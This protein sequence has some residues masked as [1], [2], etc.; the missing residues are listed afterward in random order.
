MKPDLAP[1]T[2]ALTK[3][4]PAPAYLSAQAK[5]EWRRIMPQLIARRIITP[6]RPL[7]GVSL[8]AMRAF[9]EGFP[10]YRESSV[11]LSAT[12]NKFLRE[13]SLME[14]DDYTLYSLRHSFEDRMLAAGID[15]R[16]RRDLCRAQADTGT[17]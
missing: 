5:A 3:A 2:D 10:R 14:S 17:L 16:I 15:D 7:L 12:V 11:S 6:R 9:P 4:P 8:E 13:N 1:D